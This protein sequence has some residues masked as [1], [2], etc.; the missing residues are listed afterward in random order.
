[1][2]AI[3]ELCSLKWVFQTMNLPLKKN[4]LWGVLHV[5]FDLI[6]VQKTLSCKYPTV[7]AQQFPGLIFQRQELYVWS[8][9]IQSEDRGVVVSAANEMRKVVD[10]RFQ[11]AKRKWSVPVHVECLGFCYMDLIKDELHRFARLWNNHRITPSINCKSL[12][13]RPDLL[14]YL[15]EISAIQNFLVSIDNDEISLCE[16]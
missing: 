5:L 1:M 10:G 9:S 2:A 16:K 4:I 12:S 13:G 15:P 7:S 14:Y 11:R 8:L 3:E 6:W